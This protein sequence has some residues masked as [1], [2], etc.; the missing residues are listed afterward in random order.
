MLIIRTE[1]RSFEHLLPMIKAEETKGYKYLRDED[2]G[3]VG[4]I[5][6]MTA[7]VKRVYFDDHKDEVSFED[8]TRV[9]FPNG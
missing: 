9:R 8:R 5:G 4:R 3:I 2:D 7:C 6:V 1:G